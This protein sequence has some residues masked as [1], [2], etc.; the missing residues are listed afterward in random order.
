MT[1]DLLALSVAL[2]AVSMLLAGGLWY[3]LGKTEARLA[4]LE[5]LIVKRAEFRK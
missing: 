3:R 5:K 4:D 2:N 1:V